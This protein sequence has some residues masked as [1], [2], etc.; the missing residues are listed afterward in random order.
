MTWKVFRNNF[1]VRGISNKAVNLKSY[2]RKAETISN[3]KSPWGK[4]VSWC[5]QSQINPFYCT[6]QKVINFFAKLF[7]KGLK[8]R[9]R[10]LC[11]SVIS[12]FHPHTEGKPVGQHPKIY[13]LLAR[14]YN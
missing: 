8:N 9:T 14:I 13:A 4:F 5:H 1:Y 2:S 7:E 12:V 6:L 3:Y 10:N 11:K